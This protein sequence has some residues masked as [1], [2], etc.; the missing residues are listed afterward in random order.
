ME[1]TLRSIVDVNAL[2]AEIA[3]H[4]SRRNAVFAALSGSDIIEREALRRIARFREEHNEAWWDGGGYM[5]REVEGDRR[6]F[7]RG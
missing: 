3:R 4:N 5:A 7:G 1:A 2:E 6:R